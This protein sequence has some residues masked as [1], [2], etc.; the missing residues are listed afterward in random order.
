MGVCGMG[1][2]KVCLVSC[3]ALYNGG[4]L[5]GIIASGYDLAGVKMFG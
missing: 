4:G 3:A 5:W 1:V 2:G